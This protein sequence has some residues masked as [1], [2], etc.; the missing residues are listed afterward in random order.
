[1]EMC[2]CVTILALNK[3]SDAIFRTITDLTRCRCWDELEMLT[4]ENVVLTSF[5]SH[6]KMCVCFG[7]RCEGNEI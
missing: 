5:Y 1:M 6:R 2:R 4:H 3:G 7:N